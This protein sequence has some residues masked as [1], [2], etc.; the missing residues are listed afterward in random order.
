MHATLGAF[1]AAAGQIAQPK[2]P[3]APPPEALRGSVALRLAIDLTSG[4]GGGG[5][6]VVRRLI[7][8]LMVCFVPGM[9]MKK[10]SAPAAAASDPS[11]SA[12]VRQHEF[13]LFF[14]SAIR[15]RTC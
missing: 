5:G 11:S 8:L 12:L 14:L 13:H 4:G 2:A 7:E 9:F 15:E 3:I 1:F 6:G 10:N